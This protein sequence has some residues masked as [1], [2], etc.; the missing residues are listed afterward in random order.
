MT[1]VVLVR[2]IVSYRSN[3]YV[4]NRRLAYFGKC[5]DSRSLFCRDM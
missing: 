2:K 5:F 4:S 3:Y 1:Y